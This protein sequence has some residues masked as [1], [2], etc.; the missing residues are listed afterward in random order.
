M[1]YLV[2]SPATVPF[3]EWQEEYKAALVETDCDKLRK[4]AAAAE[5]AIVSRLKVLVG[6]ADRAE[7][8]LAT[9]DALRALRFLKGSYLFYKALVN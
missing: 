7:E 6:K 8:R 1:A 9:T 5:A 2:P 4:C 3:P